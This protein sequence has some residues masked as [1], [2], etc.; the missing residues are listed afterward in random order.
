MLHNR[1]KINKFKL[2]FGK[3]HIDL[4]LQIKIKRIDA[5]L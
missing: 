2:T 3:M 5:R 1:A 4:E